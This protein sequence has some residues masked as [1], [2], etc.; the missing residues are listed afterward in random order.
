MV[1]ADTPNQSKTCT[2]PEVVD[3]CEYYAETFKKAVSWCKILLG[4]LLAPAIA[5]FA[6]EKW[7]SARDA[8]GNGKL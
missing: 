5:V 6:Y 3:F 7:R 8:V 4:L 2:K 1:M